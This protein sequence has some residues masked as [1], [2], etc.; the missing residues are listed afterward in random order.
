MNYQ[1][2]KRS[3]STI[4]EEMNV[5]DESKFVTDCILPLC[6]ILGKDQAEANVRSMKIRSMLGQYTRSNDVKNEII[7]NEKFIFSLFTSYTRLIIDNVK[8]SKISNAPKSYLSLD[9]LIIMFDDFLLLNNEFDTTMLGDI[10]RESLLD[11]KV[12]TGIDEESF[13]YVLLSLGSEIMLKGKNRKNRKLDSSTMLKG[14]KCIIE[15]I[16]DS[17]QGRAIFFRRFKIVLPKTKKKKKKKR[18]R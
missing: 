7:S 12:K 14:I 11:S 13:H 15:L 2:F 5:P 10:Y 3:L 18:D 8:N 1:M 6:D 17:Q 4:R 9:Q 16:N